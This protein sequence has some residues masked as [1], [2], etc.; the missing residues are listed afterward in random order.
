MQVQ[1][2]R[3]SCR[4]SFDMLREVLNGGLWGVGM[5]AQ[6]RIVPVAVTIADAFEGGVLPDALGSG[7]TAA[8]G[9]PDGVFPL[10]RN[11]I[12]FTTGDLGVRIVRLDIGLSGDGIGAAGPTRGHEGEIGVKRRVGSIGGAAKAGL[13]FGDLSLEYSALA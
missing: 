6:R 5:Q 13:A 4:G 3:D 1:E 10:L 11:G 2:W 9:A 7:R 12:S 8:G